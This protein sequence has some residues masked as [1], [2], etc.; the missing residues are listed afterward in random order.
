M[1]VS[2]G[3]CYKDRCIHGAWN[4]QLSTHVGEKQRQTKVKTFGGC[5]CDVKPGRALT[6]T[7]QKRDLQKLDNDFIHCC[8]IIHTRIH[9]VLTEKQHK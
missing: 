1:S 2:A 9:N 7:T 6:I 3:T 5:H 8:I 4:K